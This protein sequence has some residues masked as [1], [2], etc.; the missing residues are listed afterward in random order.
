MCSK[1]RGG[2]PKG[3]GT[4][5]SWKRR[6]DKV[7]KQGCRKVSGFCNEKEGILHV[8]IYCL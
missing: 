7:H 3:P 8:D 5:F 2:W 1:S 4:L 6:E